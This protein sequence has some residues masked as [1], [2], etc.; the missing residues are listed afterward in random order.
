MKIFTQQEK[1][2]KP[3]H[4]FFGDYSE[5]DIAI[6]QTTV[7]DD[8]VDDVLHYHKDGKEYY[9]TTEGSAI[10]EIDNAHVELRKNHIV[11]VEPYERHRLTKVLEKPFSCIVISTVKSKKD[12]II[13]EE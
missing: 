8:M 2:D 11:M 1:T 7:S 5:I 6:S 3:G 12:K 10:L 4:Y 13:I 9:V